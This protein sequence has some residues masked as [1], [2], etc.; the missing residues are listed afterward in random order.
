MSSQALSPDPDLIYGQYAGSY[1]A[2]VLRLAL[3]L[4]VFTPLQNGPATA[5]AVATNCGCD[6]FGIGAVLD[7]LCA[8]RLLEHQGEQYALTPT[9]EAFLLPKSQSYAGKWVLEETNPKLWESILL[10]LRGYRHTLPPVHWEQ[11][12]WLESYRPSQL[13]ESLDM[14]K[15]TGIQPGSRTGLRILD[16][17]CGCAVK[18]LAL[19]QADPTVRVTC[20]DRA[21]VI[22]V[23]R[24][25]AGRLQVKDQV[26]FIQGDLHT[27]DLGVARFDAALLGQI[28][29]YLS[30]QQNYDLFQRLHAALAPDGIL[31]IDVTLAAQPPDEWASLIT[32]ISWVMG[33]GKAYTFAEY[34]TWLEQAGFRSVEQLSERWLRAQL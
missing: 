22:Q 33:G 32:L 10:A 6:I 7:Y 3:Q 31:V 13:I 24:N 34:R 16:L 26:K 12:A 19:A 27:V 30:P 14:W 23:A 11:D 8:A 15:A 29:Y 5:E 17:A 4:D 9:A 20:L 25:L 1:K 18:S 21:K 2:Q 28:T